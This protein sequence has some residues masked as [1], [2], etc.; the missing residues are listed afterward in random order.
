MA[1]SSVSAP[2]A[3]SALILLRKIS[4]YKLYE[5][6]MAPSL[7]WGVSGGLCWCWVEMH[8]FT[9]GGLYSFFSHLF[10]TIRL[11][12][13]RFVSLH[14]PGAEFP[15]VVSPSSSS[16]CYI[17]LFLFQTLCTSL[18]SS[19]VPDT[20]AYILLLLSPFQISSTSTSQDHPVCPSMQDWSIGHNQVSLP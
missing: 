1:L 15:H 19:P 20:T 12:L 17:F 14:F 16:P 11:K 4:V 7:D 2:F 5:R 3:F 18:P 8:L 10:C 6:W 9:E 13:Q